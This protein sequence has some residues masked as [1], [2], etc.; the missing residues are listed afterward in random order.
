MPRWVFLLIVGSTV[1]VAVVLGVVWYVI[2]GWPRDHDRYGKVAIPGKRS[3][4]LPQGEVRLSFE[5]RVSG[6]GQTRILENPPEGLKVTLTSGSGRRLKIES[7][8]ASLYS[9]SSGDSGH[10]P[11]G[12]TEVPERGR[13]RVVTRADG[14]SASGRIT[15]G[16]KLWNPLD[17]REAGAVG[18]FLASL[19]VLMAIEVPILLMV[20]RRAA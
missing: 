1:L 9:I 19:L 17:S 2:G 13:H 18:I 5:G 10:E 4:S 15:L 8:S 3:I 12:K 7:V 6:G 20:R 11:Y 14:G 16:P